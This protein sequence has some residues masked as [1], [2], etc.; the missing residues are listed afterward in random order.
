MSSMTLQDIEI[1]GYIGFGTYSKV[2]RGRIKA[3]NHPVA[4]KEISMSQNNTFTSALREKQVDQVIPPHDNLSKLLYEFVDNVQGRPMQYLIFDRMDCDLHIFISHLNY[5]NQEAHPM[6]IKEI[7]KQILM[8][9]EFCH[10]RRVMHRDIK[11]GNFLMKVNGQHVN[12]RLTDFGIAGAI[13]ENPVNLSTNVVSLRYRPPELLLG[14]ILYGAEIDMW[15]VGCV[16]AELIQTAPLFSPNDEGDLL[17]Q[18]FQLIGTPTASSW[19]EA[20][21]L[22]MWPVNPP[23]YAQNFSDRLHRCGPEAFNLLTRMLTANPNDRISAEA[24]MVHPYFFI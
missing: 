21:A 19:E 8:A 1:S 16:F 2:Y 14:C 10:R 23:Q 6:L 18:I 11:P 9:V 15:S 3:T 17:L 24:A 5:I 12:I 20:S 13:L 7:M 22:P 4:I